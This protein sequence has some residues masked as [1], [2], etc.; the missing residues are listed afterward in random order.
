ML[1]ACSL[2]SGVSSIV[3]D[4]ILHVSVEYQVNIRFLNLPEGP[5]HS[6][7]YIILDFSMCWP[8]DN[9][10]HGWSINDEAVVLIRNPIWSF[11]LQLSLQSWLCFSH[12]HITRTVKHCHWNRRQFVLQDV[13]YIHLSPWSLQSDD[14]RVNDVSVIHFDC[15]D[16]DVFLH[17]LHRLDLLADW[18]IE[19]GGP[20]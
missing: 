12:S 14:T 2:L 10:K 8:R 6:L 1:S 7:V 15:T 17:Q 3:F 19:A 11:Y 20:R 16:T 13:V 9:P 4:A 18:S 5:C